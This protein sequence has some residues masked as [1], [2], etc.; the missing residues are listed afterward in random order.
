MPSCIYLLKFEFPAKTTRQPWI[1]PRGNQPV[2][3]VLLKSSLSKQI[4]QT[5]HFNHS[6][7]NKQYIKSR[8]YERLS[9]RF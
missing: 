2:T 9:L 5:Q 3:K 4:K 8:I 7:K 6:L 1:S